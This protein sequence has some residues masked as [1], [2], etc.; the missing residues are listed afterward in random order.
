MSQGGMVLQCGAKDRE[1]LKRKH[2]GA[3]LWCLGL[4]KYQACTQG[5]SAA[6][7]DDTA[8]LHCDKG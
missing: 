4:I 8:S 3:V 5:I 7:L 1:L 6:T 2:C